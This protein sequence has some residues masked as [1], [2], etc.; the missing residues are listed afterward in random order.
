LDNIETFTAFDGGPVWKSIYEE[1][2]VL[3]KKFTDLK[4]RVNKDKFQLL[5]SAESC[6]EATLL[7][8]VVSGL[9]ASVNTHISEGFEDLDT[10]ELTSNKTYWLQSVGN[11]PDRV[12]NLHFLYAA[13]VK[14]VSLLEQ[15]LIQNDLETGLKDKD[16]GKAKRLMVQLLKSLGANN[17]D[18]SFKE[19]NF[20][21]G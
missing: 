2:C 15:T 4:H 14:A 6:T 21:Q 20:F 11:Y 18:E 1:N 5:D 3:D 9:H 13:V 19:K 12:K 17:C 16:D 7:Y 8:H 10:G